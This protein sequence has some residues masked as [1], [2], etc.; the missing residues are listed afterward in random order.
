MVGRVMSDRII[1]DYVVGCRK[2]KKSGSK[3]AALIVSHRHER[4]HMFD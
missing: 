1:D 4:K 3:M 2:K